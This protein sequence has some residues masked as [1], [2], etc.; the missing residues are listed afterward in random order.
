LKNFYGK[1]VLKIKKFINRTQSILSYLNREAV[2]PNKPITLEIEATNRCNESCWMCP[3]S[4]MKRD[5][6][7]LSLDLLENI[8]EQN[9]NTLELVNLFHCGE[10][11][12]H[13][14]IGE[15][16]NLCHR[17]NVK[18][19][20]TTTGN[21][22]T[23]E[24]GKELIDSGLDMLVLSLDAVTKETYSS[25]RKSNFEDVVRNI[26]RF[27]ELKSKLG[28]K[29]FVQVQMVSMDMNRHEIPAFI[30]RWKK[31]ADSVRVKRFYNTADIAAIIGQKLPDK[32]TIVKPSPC[33][34]LW[35]EPVVC[36][37]GT[38]LP[39]CID[40]I[41]EAPIG[42][43]NDNTFMEVWNGEKMLNMRKL[44]IEGRYSEID[45]CKHCTIFQVNLP[46]VL[47]STLLDDL[48]IRK[49]NPIFEKLD[50]VKGLK[51]FNHF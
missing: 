26:D 19:L 38:V 34:M 28:R 6:G 22:L 11:L 44:H 17:K 45:V 32:K 8:I 50:T 20:I 33:I 16:I 14:H 41:G 36:W 30:S 47:G 18:V 23:L 48:T 25:I 24:K 10:P 3:H 46:F 29:P 43:I 39:C 35:R 40:L 31:K 37:D 21:L 13:P 5:K 51:K 7:D 12:L 9:K 2:L 27:I 42:N 4:L 15:L 1:D 49:V